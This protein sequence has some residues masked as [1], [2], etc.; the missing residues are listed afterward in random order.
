MINLSDDVLNVMINNSVLNAELANCYGGPAVFNLFTPDNTLFPRITF[1][2]MDN[3]DDRYADDEPKTARIMF[4]VDIWLDKENP[5]P[6]KIKDAVYKSMLSI[7]FF[8][9][10]TGPTLYEQDTGVIHVPMRFIQYKEVN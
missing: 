2:E 4:Q 9:D 1:F 8:C 7:G 6:K 3:T 10:S 5:N